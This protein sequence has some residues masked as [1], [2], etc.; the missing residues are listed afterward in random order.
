MAR[1]ICS[2]T[3]CVNIRFKGS[4]FCFPHK[5][6]IERAQ[7]PAES[8]QLPEN[9]GVVNIKNAYG[10][11]EPCIWIPQAQFAELTRKAEAWDAEGAINYWC[12]LPPRFGKFHLCVTMNL[13]DTWSAGVYNESGIV[14]TKESVMY[15]VSDAKTRE[16]AVHE[17]AHVL[18]IGAVAK[19]EQV[20]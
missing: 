17:L 13:D 19:G 14:L 8:E 20:E 5:D 10:F 9:F 15:G 3:G 1:E 18:G 4:Q 11:M 6:D 12:M 16:Q 2:I 7:P